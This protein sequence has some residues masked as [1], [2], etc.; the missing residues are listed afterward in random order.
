MQTLLIIF[1]SVMLFTPSFA[2]TAVARNSTLEE[3]YEQEQRK[4]RKEGERESDAEERERAL[5]I[6]LKKAKQA[7][8]TMIHNHEDTLDI[9]DDIERLKRDSGGDED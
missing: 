7:R 6:K 8:R 1:V 2:T 3:K 4:S 5:R 9:D